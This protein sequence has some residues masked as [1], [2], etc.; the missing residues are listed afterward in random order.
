MRGDS[1]ERPGPSAIE[2][3]VTDVPNV[4]TVDWIG[5]S[6]ERGAPIESLESARLEAGTGLAGDHHA[7][8]G[9]SK[10]QVT[11]VQAEHLPVVASL[12]GQ[13]EVVPAALRRNVVVRGINVWALR[14]LRFRL[15]GAVLEG[16]GPCAP[17]SRMNETIGTGGYLAMRGHGGSTARVVEAGEVRVGDRGE[18]LGTAASAD[19]AE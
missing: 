17:C 4:G 14:T 6:A 11:I 8:S 13:D 18:V 10:R 2:R 5:R 9:R 15:G 3:L 12:A 19:A 1:A 16:T 7:T